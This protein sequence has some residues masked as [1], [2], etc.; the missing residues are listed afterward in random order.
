MSERLVSTWVCGRGGK[1]SERLAVDFE[2]ERTV[3]NDFGYEE[4][5]L[6]YLGQRIPYKAIAKNGRILAIVKRVYRLIPNEL[7]KHKVERMSGVKIE[8]VYE[9]DARIYI[10]V[11]PVGEDDEKKI[12]AMVVNSVDATLS[13]RVYLTINWGY[14]HIPLTKVGGI[15]IQSVKRIHKKNVKF[16]DLTDVVYGV[17][18]SGKGV[19]DFIAQVLSLEAREYKD[20]FE[21]LAELIPKKYV[22]DAL[23]ALDVI[24]D[25]R[26]KDVYELIS[27]RLWNADIDMRTKMA[28]LDKLHECLWIIA[29]SRGW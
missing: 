8:N 25:I 10:T 5:Y 13:L 4:K 18:E 26:V 6:K 11:V 23:V 16:E 17:L 7:V 29:E 24:K 21:G 20:V 19:K 15:N 14:G 3:K 22:K 1:M 9:D 2:V 28:W 12:G 27:T